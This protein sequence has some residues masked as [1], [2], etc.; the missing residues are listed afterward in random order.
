MWPRKDTGDPIGQSK[1]CVSGPGETE[2][3]WLETR[4]T[5]WCL[6]NREVH[7]GWEAP[8]SKHHFSPTQLLA[9][10]TA[11]ALPSPSISWDNHT[12]NA[13]EAEFYPD[14]HLLNRPYSAFRD[15]RAQGT[16]RVPQGG[17][18]QSGDLTVSSS[19]YSTRCSDSCSKQ[20]ASSTAEVSLCPNN[21]KWA[22]Q[23]QTSGPTWARPVWVS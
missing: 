18:E 7:R 6:G 21:I 13:T 22:K 4:T 17:Q 10:R 1:V 2:K 20:I 3:H 12:P 14:L 19:L 23:L 5:T 16:Q 11:P 9:S 8:T 15:S